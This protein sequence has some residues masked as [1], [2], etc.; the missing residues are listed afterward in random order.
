MPPVSGSTPHDFLATRIPGLVPALRNEAFKTRDD[1]V[2][3]IQTL[4]HAAN[5]Y[6]GINGG[7]T[8][9]CTQALMTRRDGRI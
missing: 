9:S 2:V 8:R 7:N 3:N 5:R 4:R 1:N 6:R